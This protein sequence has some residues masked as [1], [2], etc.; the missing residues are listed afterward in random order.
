[1]EKFIIKDIITVDFNLSIRECD[2]IFMPQ[3][4]ALGLLDEN[5]EIYSFVLK[6]HLQKMT[7]FNLADKPVK[8]I[9]LPAK[10]YK[11]SEIENICD[12][13]FFVDD[14]CE[15]KLFMK[16]DI[17]SSHINLLHK[18][19]QNLSCE[20]KKALSLCSKAADEI[21]MPIFLIGGIVR[22]IILCKKSLD[23]D[24]SVQE[25]AIEFAHFL[26]KKYPDLLEIKEIH[27]EF[28]TVKVV[29]NMENKPIN[30]DIASTRE[31]TYP[32]PASLPVVKNIGADLCFDV[33]RRDFSINSMALSLNK[34]T[35][36]ELT[37]YLGG[38][39]DIKHS[40]IRILH[41]LSFVDDPSRILRALK[42]SA[43][44]DYELEERTHYLQKECLQS[45]LF[46]DLASDRLKLELKQVLN[47]NRPD[48]F[49][50]FLKEGIY[51]LISTEISSENLPDGEVIFQNIEKY[52]SHLENKDHIWLVYLGVM[53]A[54]F[55]KEQILSLSKKLNL[56]GVELKV[57]LYINSIVKNEKTILAFSTMFEIY[58][59]FECF[60]NES[61]IG[62]LSLI[63]DKKI[64]DYI[65]IY[66]QKL[67]FI[68]I[69]TTGKNL[70]ERAM[71]PSPQFGEILRDILK[72]K[73]NGNITS[74]E[75]EAAY[76]DNLLGKKKNI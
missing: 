61:L 41:P 45:G 47:L 63:K 51:R 22:D 28:K 56:S 60:F 69:N 65:D 76:L 52:S 4:A 42:F 3:D 34:N 5:R 21:N 9:A 48:V 33:I 54:H 66:L 24:I 10:I 19:E 29:F 6:E 72:E 26:K 68:T 7:A 18:Y 59:F 11:V 13:S 25:N 2:S 43:R 27:E 32:Y 15:Y 8:M 62:A 36:C 74:D 20:V 67:Q 14:G 31:E 71:I 44:L 57:L 49:N 1:M 70:I 16:K 73:I 23:I 53:F 38:Y 39:E 46:D 55:E 50:R 35:F 17:S 37:D 12:H 40:S 58:E 30:I 75:D 64:S